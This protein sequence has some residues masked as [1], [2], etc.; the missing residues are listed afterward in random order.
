MPIPSPFTP[1]VALSVALSLAL[2]ACS[3][4]PEPSPT[5][6]AADADDATDAELDLVADAVPD[7]D[8]DAAAD[9][10]LD[11]AL[12]PA[13]DPVTDAVAD[14]DVALDV[15]P[16][17]RVDTCVGPAE[18]AIEN[19]ALPPGFCAW[20]WAR[21]LRRPRGLEIVGGDVLV[22]ESE[23]RQI[24]VLWD[25]D[26]D[27]VSG[28]GERAL[29]AA[30]PGLN[31]GILVHGGFLYASSDTTVYRWA[32]TAGARAD[33]GEPVTVIQGIPG[34]GHVT[35]TLDVD[36]EGRL[37]VTVGSGTNVDA[38]PSRSRM[39]RFTLPDPLEAPL[40]WSSGEVFADGMRNIVGL[41][42]DLQGRLWGVENGLDNLVRDDLGDVHEDNPAEEVNLF[43]E[44]GLFYGYP[45][46]WSEFLLPE[47][48]GLGA[49][50]Q[51]V[52]PQFVGQEP[53][54]DAW[55]RDPANVVP[56]VFSMQAHAAPLD[57]TFYEGGS[58]P[59]EYVG[60]ALIS[61]HGSWNRS[62]PTGY[63]VVRLHFEGGH[64]VAL[65]P[66]F[67]YSGAG[68]IA[69]EWRH[70]PVGIH[71]GPNGEVFVT[72]DSDGLVIVLGHDGT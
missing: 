25:D 68:D 53:Y 3:D 33:L 16:G 61:F 22:V 39:L 51:W 2:A 15:E 27:G 60:D 20:I 24:T 11:R 49:G 29:L 14:A 57:I 44:P 64:P 19:A 40:E 50:A 13:A 52:T 45:Y 1:S 10:A 72:S 43:V 67:E 26:G 21:D 59:H 70:R 6:V 9:P 41:G 5:D 71:N 65:N 18:A 30:A 28:E 12:D 7:G 46:C 32:Y 17:P 58:L 69:Q 35:R 56:P 47:G 63:K 66:V 8:A 54:T 48:V 42:W 23:R 36:P 37:Y 55:C 4:D 34:G 62:V 38:D 31:H